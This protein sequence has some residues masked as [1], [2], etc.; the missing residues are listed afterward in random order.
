MRFG[1]YIQYLPLNSLSLKLLLAYVIG[2]VLSIICIGLVLL[3]LSA[4]QN[5]L[6]RS[7]NLMDAAKGIACELVFNSQNIP[8]AVKDGDNKGEDA[9]FFFDSLSEESAYRVLDASGRTVLSSLAGD[10]F[11]SSSQS[12]R[13]IKQGHFVFSYQ[14]VLMQGVSTTVE[15]GGQTWVVQ[16]AM[17]GRFLKLID[18]HIA[19]PFMMKGVAVFSLVL[20]FVFGVCA[21]ITLRYTLK[22][23]RQ[24][25]E[26]AATISPGSLHARL[27]AGAVPAEITPLVDSFNRVLDRL[28]QGYRIQQEFLATAAHELKTPLAL[29]RA[30]IELKDDGD[31]RAALLNDVAHMTRQVQ[32]LLLLAEV[33]EAQ[34]YNLATVDVAS[35]VREVVRYLQ[36]MAGAAHVQVTVVQAFGVYWQA[37]HAALF[38]LLKNLLEN[39]IQH[40]PAGTQVRIETDNA[41]LTVRDWGPG[42]SEEQLSHLF[43]RFWRGAHRRD[44]GAGLGLA[45]CQEIAVAHG[46]VLTAC[47]ANPGLCFKLACP[48]EH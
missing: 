9:W 40:A 45:I 48:P 37:D 1:K 18:E 35:V 2:I 3:V 47:R 30:Q 20:L 15:R 8:I 23:L 22:P 14:G 10:L 11:W 17:S 7:T 36:P 25:S 32:Q 33:S 12:A 38:T 24:V 6:L 26:S 29:I 39:A 28:E 27:C 41:A 16:V 44:H 43:V 4:Q 31:A 42:A 19:V 21:Y 46:W 34:N 13:H 5:R